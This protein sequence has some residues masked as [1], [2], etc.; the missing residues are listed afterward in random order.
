M[1]SNPATAVRITAAWNY[2]SEKT[3]TRVE[4]DVWTISP[5]DDDRDDAVERAKRELSRGSVIDAHGNVAKVGYPG[6]AGVGY[7]YI[8][9][10]GPA[11]Q[12]AYAGAKRSAGGDRSGSGTFEDGYEA[13]PGTEGYD[14]VVSHAEN[15]VLTAFR[16]DLRRY[17]SRELATA[18]ETM[19][20]PRREQEPTTQEPFD[21]FRN[22]VRI[23]PRG[24]APRE[25]SVDVRRENNERQDQ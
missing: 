17:G 13:P 22:T 20:G 1:S 25:Y 12:Q 19:D 14:Q 2:E 9:S 3:G 11:S 18:A 5:D 24:K 21:G 4:V 8:D 7:R 15:E 6:A 23:F 10:D 16:A